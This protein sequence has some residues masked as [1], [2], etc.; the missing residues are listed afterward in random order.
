MSVDE[1]L[2]LIRNSENSKAVSLA[3]LRLFRALM[4][5]PEQELRTRIENSSDSVEAEMAEWILWRNKLDKSFDNL[6]QIVRTSSD[7][8]KIR[9]AAILLGE[10]GYMEAVE[11]LIRLMVDTPNSHVR[12]GAALGLRDLAD[13]RALKPIVETI[14]RNPESASTFVYALET[15]DCRE[16]VEFLIALFVSQPEDYM[17]RCSI[18]E[19]I[20]KVS[21]LGLSDELLNTCMR[22]LKESLTGKRDDEYVRHSRELMRLLEV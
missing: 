6:I 2:R 22:R 10:E 21:I 3:K 20:K 8:E 4:N 14:K 17:L 11:P 15:L 13:Q 5:E 12:E 7:E 16:I 9:E 18:I 19:C 1:L